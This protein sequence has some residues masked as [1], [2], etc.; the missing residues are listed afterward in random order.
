MTDTPKVRALFERARNL[1]PAEHLAF[2]L[3][4]AGEDA[5]LA[6]GVLS[7]LANAT[8]KQTDPDAAQDRVSL[9]GDVEGESVVLDAIKNR[10]APSLRYR[11]VKEIASG[12]MGKVSQ[13]RDV[14]LRRQLAM[15]VMLDES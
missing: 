5:D 6:N 4:E 14:D 9:S 12:G 1:P 7:L 2:V 8:P 11:H 13:V 3:R 10:A 15:K